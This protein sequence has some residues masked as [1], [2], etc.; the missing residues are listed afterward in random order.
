MKTI[1]LCWVSLVLYS[2]CF[3]KLQG[4]LVP[5]GT[6]H[7]DSQCKDYHSLLVNSSQESHFVP[8]ITMPKPL[9]SMFYFYSVYSLCNCYHD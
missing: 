9:N 2:R 1:Y 5:K 4:R 6:I 8:L 3:R 7:P